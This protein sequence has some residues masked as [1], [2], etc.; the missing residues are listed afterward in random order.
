MRTTLSIDDDVASLLEQEVR[1]SGE[2]F[3]WTINRLL[4]LGLMAA[5][6]PRERKPFVVKPRSLNLPSYDC[7]EDILEFLEGPEHR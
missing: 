1:R 6:Q 2:S 3:K 7:V 4:R 5:N